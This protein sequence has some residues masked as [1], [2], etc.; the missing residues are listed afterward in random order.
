MHPLAAEVRRLTA[1]VDALASQVDVARHDAMEASRL[2]DD[3]L[4]T[5]SHELRTPLNAMLGWIQMLRAHGEDPTIRA[6]AIEVIDRNARAEAHLV[7]DVLDV[8][9]IIT[10]KL[11]IHVRPVDL[12]S[13]VAAGCDTLRPS[14]GV[15]RQELTI[16]ADDLPGVVVGDADRLQQ[17]VWNLVA[18][19]AKFTLPGGRITV[20]IGATNAHAF[21]SVADSGVGIPA[22]FVPHVFERFSQC[23]GTITRAHGGLGL[24]L[25]IVRHLVELHGGSVEAS[26]AGSNRG[27][28]F[29]VRLPLRTI[30]HA[31]QPGRTA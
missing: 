17:V 30:E 8:S 31:E 9:R 23:D 15:R 11:R 18:N 7:S 24:G 3:F 27:A 5:L 22:E 28:T 25:A 26:S 12:R 13:V 19:A 1:L 14:I 2:K 29:T 21:I 6:R 10:G 20:R 16:D 4:S